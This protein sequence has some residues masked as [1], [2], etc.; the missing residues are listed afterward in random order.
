MHFIDL[1]AQY[2]AYRD[3]MDAAIREVMQSAQ[4]I[5]G[6][7]VARLETELARFVGVRHAVGFASGTDSLLAV[8]MAWGIGP[9]T[10]VITTPFTFIATAEVIALLGATPVFVDV[11]PD[12]LNLDPAG[13]EPAITPRTRA[14]IPVGLYGQC[15]DLDAINAVA[16]RHGLLCMEDGC[17]SFGAT[18]RGRRSCGLS[19]AGVTSFF[20]AKPLGCCGDGGMAFTDDETLAGRLRVIREHGQV[21]RYQHAMPGFNGRLD[22]LQAAIL[23]AKLPHFEAEIAARQRVADY[24]R[25]RLAGRVRLPVVRPDC[26]SVYAQFTIRTPHREAVQRHLTAE[27]IPTAIHYPAPLHQQP[28][29]AGLGYRAEAFP[30]SSQAAREVLS[31]PMHP[32]LTTDEQDRV[33]DALLAVLS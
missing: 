31:L 16:D 2:Q 4:F 33:V 27:G 6:P 10:E 19:A 28:V 20:P 3:S 14:I 30:V 24:Y 18:Y 26:L 1:Q 17:Q 32:F 11:D 29:F 12:T 5:N 21:A 9:G 7:Q 8:L 22:T 23:L 25:T 15:A 13:L